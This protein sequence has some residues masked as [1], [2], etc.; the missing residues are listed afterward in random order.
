[1]KR[2]QDGMMVEIAEL[3]IGR[4]FGLSFGGSQNGL[5]FQIAAAKA[6]GSH[7]LE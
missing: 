1:M 3:G 4:A 5:S 6:Q 2:G 7:R